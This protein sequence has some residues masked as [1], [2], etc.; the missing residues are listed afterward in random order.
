MPEDLKAECH[1]MLRHLQWTQ[2]EAL[3]LR[4]GGRDFHTSWVTLRADTTSAFAGMVNPNSPFRP[5][6]RSTYYIDKDPS[7]FR[8]ILNYLRGGAHIE[9][10]TLPSDERYLLELLLEARF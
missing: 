6:G 1:N 7:Q 5:C 4:L 8:L 10:R 9:S 3:I 2:E